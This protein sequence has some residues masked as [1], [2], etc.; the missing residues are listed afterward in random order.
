[1]LD[2]VRSWVKRNRTNFAL[3][4]GL[5]GVGYVTTQYVFSKL[6]EARERMSVDRISNDN[7]RLRFQQNQEDCTF[8]V[9]A[10]LPTATE[11]ILEVFPVE[12]ITHELQQ[13]RADR[14]G[15]PAGSSDAAA[16]ELSSGPP[17]VTD[18]DGRSLRSFQSESFVHASQMAESTS[19]SPPQEQ[20]SA[21]PKTKSQLWNELKI[22][23]ITRTFTLLYTLSL[24]TLLTRIQLNLLGRR[25]YM[26]SVLSLASPQQDDT[27]ITLEDHDDEENTAG[28]QS[29][30]NDF[31]TNR[32]Y[33]TF[34]WWLLHRGWQEL[35]D[36]VRVAVTDIFGPLN[37]REDITLE[38]LSEL[39]LQVRRQIEGGTTDDR[40]SKK[41]LP[42][43]LPPASLEK[44]VLSS[45]GMPS[46]PPPSASTT[47]EPL[48][49][50]SLRRLLDETSD[51]IDSPLFTQVLTRLLDAVFTHLVD[52]KLAMQAF[53][54][55]S[56]Q[57]AQA[58]NQEA[59]DA[60]RVHDPAVLTTKLATVLAAT[61][62]QAH[63]IGS[64]V[65][66]EY[67]Q[68][69]D[70]VPELEAFAAVI[71]SSNFEAEAAASASASGL[72]SPPQ[73]TYEAPEEERKS[74]AAS[75]K[76][77]TPVAKDIDANNSGFEAIWGK[78]VEQV[79]RSP[80]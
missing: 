69:A 15:K 11:H 53:K 1:M 25:N 7:L 54:V 47:S 2:G 63:S 41:Y 33:L 58:S 14:L 21:P 10:L 75:E 44:F 17:S 70:A 36:N 59:S 31:E 49:S 73:T 37:P 35:S 19:G 8:T 71:Y 55:P 68:S 46:M 24:L 79:E 16:S 48:Q 23:S 60:S 27:T 29:Y 62:R 51:L 76:G 22:S 74:A 78:A 65:P 20:S 50:V 39:T 64:A 56:S 12:S 3:G 38:R 28:G 18:D 5:V 42:Y 77:Y 66:N 30:R 80:K 32:Q 6:Q 72:F 26:S 34:S 52:T 13:K 40:R 45:S 67:V 61:T 9:L 4:F 57:S 43:L